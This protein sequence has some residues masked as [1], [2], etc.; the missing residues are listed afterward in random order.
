M[1]VP[2]YLM[3]LVIFIPT[4]TEQIYQTSSEESAKT[5]YNGCQY[6][7]EHW[8]GDLRCAVRTGGTVPWLAVPEGSHG[9]SY[10]AHA[11][12]APF[13]CFMSYTRKLHL[14]E[15]C[16][17]IFYSNKSKAAHGDVSAL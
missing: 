16:E 2:L 3:C 9:F 14:L 1:R 12:K 6:E 15:V 8:K 7:I 13:L 5:L 11:L 4:K 10:H 17:N